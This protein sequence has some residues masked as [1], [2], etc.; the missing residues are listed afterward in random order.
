MP[1]RRELHP[2]GTAS[3]PYRSIACWIGT[4]HSCT[5][6]APPAATDDVPVIYEECICPCHSTPDPSVPVGAVA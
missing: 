6:P 1:P 3:D 2:T 4:H 5:D